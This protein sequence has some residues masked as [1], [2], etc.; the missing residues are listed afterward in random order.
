MQRKEFV[1]LVM[2]WLIGDAVAIYAALNLAYDARYNLD[3]LPLIEKLV[4]ITERYQIV[5]PVAVPLWLLV[6]AFN[7]LYDRRY[8]LNGLQEYAK[9]VIACT[10]GIL[11]LVILSFIE[12]NLSVSRSWLV[13]CWFLTICFVGAWRFV[14]R[15]VVRL[16]RRRGY[17]LTRALIVGANE[18][19]KAIARQLEPATQSGVQ[20]VGFLDDY[21]PNDSRVLGD[22]RVLERPTALAQIARETRATEAIVVQGAIAWESFMEIIQRSTSSLDNL[23]IK[24][25]PGFY[26]ILATGVRLSQ[27]GFVP[28]LAIEKNRITGVDAWMKNILDYGVSLFALILVSPILLFTTILVK[29]VAPGSVFEPYY[30]LGAREK[31]FTTWKFRTHYA[32]P[33]RRTL[34]YP[35]ARWL[36]RLGLDKLPQFINI[37]RGE[38]SLVG[39]RPIPMARAAV[40]QEWLPTLLAVKP[41]FTGPWV[42]GAREVQSLED[43]IRLDLYYI[44]SWTIWLDLQILL[45]TALRLFEGVRPVTKR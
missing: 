39:P 35:F 11:V 25:S 20:V 18:H 29:L 22:L 28:L 44:R 12:P 33:A 7:H 24:L 3:W 41:G 5:I 13:L 43:E 21:L 38:M 34:D 6:F 42:V 14:M 17:L 4:P 45:Q 26:E 40:Y 2:L 32:D 37:L 9:I 16:A 30:V 15:R 1:Y 19:A 31:Q 36:Y 27:D 8:T 23:D 10:L